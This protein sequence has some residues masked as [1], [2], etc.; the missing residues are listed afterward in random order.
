MLTSRG[1]RSIGT[2]NGDGFL[3]TKKTKKDNDIP[4]WS[5]FYDEL[6]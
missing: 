2:N 6:A 3:Q 1:K 5:N 4:A